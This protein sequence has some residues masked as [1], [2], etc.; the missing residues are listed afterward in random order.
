[1]K[2]RLVLASASPRRRQIMEDMG[3]DFEVVPPTD[4]A[5]CGMCSGE[6]PYELVARLAFQKATDVARRV[7]GDAVIIG[8]DT[9][10]ECRGVI[11][12]KPRDESDAERMLRLLR[13][14]RHRVLS[15]IC[16]Y[17]LPTRRINVEVDITT[18][19]MDHVPDEALEAYVASGHWEGKAGAFGYQDGLDWLHIE[20]GSETNVVGLPRERL[21]RMLEELGLADC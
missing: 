13:G 10:A 9:V 20:S 7:P 2:S 12:G 21:E 4:S 19:R 1:M 3:L 11:L 15:G 14:Q 5:E 18:L 6:S 16:V 8:C 17:Q